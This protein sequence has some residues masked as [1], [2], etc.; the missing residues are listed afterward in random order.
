MEG[1]RRQFGL[2]EPLRRGMELRIAAAGEWMPLALGGAS[3]VHADILAGRDTEIGWEDVF[4][5]KFA[6]LGA[7]R[8]FATAT[9]M[10][11]LIARS[12]DEFREPADFHTEIETRLRMNW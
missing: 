2:A 7:A 3:G 5:G 10:Q 1:L 8:S 11:M 6:L 4:K 9:G 12:G